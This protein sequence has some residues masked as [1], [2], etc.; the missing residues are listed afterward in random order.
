MDDVRREKRM[1]MDEEIRL[2]AL[3]SL[4]KKGTILFANGST[5]YTNSIFHHILPFIGANTVG[6][7]KAWQNPPPPVFKEDKRRAVERTKQ[8]EILR[9]P[10][11]QR[12]TPLLP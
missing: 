6:I 7:K 11:I 12:T 3:T 1:I 2:K 4:E 8:L 5:N 9:H 10:I